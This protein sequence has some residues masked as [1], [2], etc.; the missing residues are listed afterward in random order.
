MTPFAPISVY[1]QEFGNPWISRRRHP[2]NDARSHKVWEMLGE[3]MACKQKTA[4]QQLAES[5]S[6]ADQMYHF[7]NNPR[8]AH[9]ELIKM[10]CSVK[11]EVLS[12]RHVLAVGDSTSF[13]L[14]KHKNRIQDPESIGVLNDGKTLGFHSHTSIVVDA[15][16]AGVLGVADILYW[17][18]WE[19]GKKQ[20]SAPD[21]RSWEEKE[22]YRWAIGATNAKAVLQA[23]ER[24]TFLFD[25][26]ADDFDLFKHLIFQESSECIIRS[27]QNRKFRWEGKVLKANNFHAQFEAAGTYELD[28]PELD[29]Y[30]WT[31]GKRIRRQART[32]TME[33][34]YQA[35]ELLAPSGYPKAEP[36]IPLCLVE[37]RET[38]EQL[39]E[40]E[41][42]II[43]RLWTTH[44]VENAE[45]AYLIVYYYTLRW[46]IEQ[47][48]RTIKKQGF[49]IEGTQLE[50]FDA[51][52]RQTTMTIKAACTVLQLTYA[53]NRL[54]CQ[55]TDEVFDQQGQQ[56][57]RQVNERLQGK[58]EKQKNPFPQHRLS[59]AAWIIARLGG[60]KGYQSQKPPGPI[61]MKK[62][63]EKFAI[64]ME[65]FKV[66]NSS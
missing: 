11:P 32:A 62:G 31:S 48:F 66:L 30:S 12:G 3:S 29:H 1:G 8:V 27:N 38:T 5:T 59:W 17:T 33:I 54:D 7:Y 45:Q 43:W 65:A 56:V 36:S 53:R 28:I 37:A 25:H 4:I 34:R 41:K 44:K 64:Y 22:S 19:S 46:I 20:A 63:L 57:L 58:T 39:P 13:N 16:T 15:R 24:V 51:I 55:P 40:G 23:A 60:W 6:Q 9:A 14:S 35:V 52:L 21:N 49:D 61:T 42:P 50:T 10:N 26:E 2:F 18:R 47:L